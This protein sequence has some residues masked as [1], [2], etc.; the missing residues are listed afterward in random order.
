MNLANKV[1]FERW[2]LV[3]GVWRETYHSEKQNLVVT[4]GLNEIQNEF[5][6]GSAYTA[7][8][9]VGL[10]DNSMFT[11]IALG[12]T[13]AQING[14]NGWKESVSYSEATRQALIMGTP[15]AGALDNSMNQAVF[16]VNANFT[17]NGAFVVTSNVKNG[18]AGI[19]IGAAS[20][21]SPIDYLIGQQIRITVSS[22]LSN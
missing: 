5:W 22:T 16:T 3:R 11:A 10:I 8:L 13:A 14:T 20:A 6:I 19:L 2:E 15:V 17:L 12:D 18:T 7:A 21:M 9:Y 1:R 4:T